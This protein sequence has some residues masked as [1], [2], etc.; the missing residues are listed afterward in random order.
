VHFTD[1][2][3]EEEISLVSVVTMATNTSLST[4]SSGTFFPVA[5]EN[6]LRQEPREE[7]VLPVSQWCALA[8]GSTSRAR[9]AS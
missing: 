7:E 5:S 2:F 4:W 9:V 1:D 8:N 3:Y 6:T